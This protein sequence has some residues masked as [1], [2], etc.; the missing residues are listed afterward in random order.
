MHPA[1]PPC[2]RKCR[3]RIRKEKWH[4]AALA[5]LYHSASDF[6]SKTHNFLPEFLHFRQIAKRPPLCAFCLYAAVHTALVVDGLGQ[7]LGGKA[8]CGAPCPVSAQLAG[9]IQ[10]CFRAQTQPVVHGD[11]GPV[12]HRPQ[13]CAQQSDADIIGPDGRQLLCGG[14]YAGQVQVSGSG[15]LF[16]FGSAVLPPVGQ[17]WCYRGCRDTPR[18]S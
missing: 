17:G 10:V 15:S 13:R 14:L 12:S 16:L 1:P 2:F 9:G 8:V 3:E 6:T 18:C 4:N 7:C 5:T 11:D